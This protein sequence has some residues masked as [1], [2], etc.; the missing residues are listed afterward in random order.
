MTLVRHFKTRILL[1]ASTPYTEVTTE[2]PVKVQEQLLEAVT[3]V[4]EFNVIE[5]TATLTTHRPVKIDHIN[6]LVATPDGYQMRR[7]F[8]GIVNRI[9]AVSFPHS[10]TVTCTGPLAKLRKTRTTDYA[11]DSVLDVEV[12]KYVLTWCGILFDPTDIQGWNYFLGTPRTIYWRAGQSGAEF[13]QEID[14]VFNMATIEIGEGRV[15]RIPYSLTPYDYTSDQITKSF[16]RGQAGSTFY[17]NERD[18]GDVDAIQNFWRINGMSWTGEKDSADEG[19]NYQ[20]YAEAEADNAALG[21]GVRI[22][23][24]FSS[25]LIQ[26]PDLAQ[27]IAQRQ[28]KWYNREPDTVRIETSNDARLNVGDV[29]GVRDSA[30]GIDLPNA[31]RYLIL[32]VTREGDLMTLDCIGGVA[33][34]TGDVTGGIEV[35]CGTQQEDGTCVKDPSG[36]PNDGPSPQKPPDSPTGHCDPI[37]DPTC[38]PGVDYPLPPAPNTEDPFVDCTEQPVGVDTGEVAEHM[39]A[40]TF[41]CLTPGWWPRCFAARG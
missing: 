31:K 28:M 39:G 36:G 5:E 41:D 21:V 2:T 6:Q 29:I 20:V 1:G 35:C 7:I 3:N 24:D 15:V 13:L 10:V 19:C 40:G 16:V 17:D 32:N 9:N 4:A 8:T 23:G 33:G 25:D 38:I 11:F 22:G 26:D 12:V 14:R 27:Y 34:A 18:R 30:Y 37:A